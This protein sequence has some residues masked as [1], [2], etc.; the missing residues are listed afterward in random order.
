MGKFLNFLKNAAIEL[1]G[2]AM[3]LSEKDIEKLKKDGTTEFIPDLIKSM[4]NSS[5]EIAKIQKKKQL[6]KENRALVM[7]QEYRKAFKKRGLDYDKLYGNKYKMDLD[8]Y[9]K[10]INMS[11]DEY[12]QI[13]S[14]IKAEVNSI[15]EYNCF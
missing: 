2:S 4:G 5:A 15:M 1:G 13:L 11:R 3:N 14:E 7:T 12:Y 9:L 6:E 10:T 8:Y